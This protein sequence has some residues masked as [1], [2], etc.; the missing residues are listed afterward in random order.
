MRKGSRLFLA[1]IVIGVVTAILDLVTGFQVSS[2]RLSGLV[3]DM[4]WWGS[5]LWIGY[6]Y[7]KK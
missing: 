7:Y 1:V 4:A 5:G 2:M 6:I 3:H